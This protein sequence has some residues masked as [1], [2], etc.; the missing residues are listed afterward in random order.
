[1]ARS[2]F[3]TGKEDITVLAAIGLRN[4]PTI[5][6]ANDFLSLLTHMDNVGL[7][8]SGRDLMKIFSSFADLFDHS[9]LYE[10]IHGHLSCFDVFLLLQ[11]LRLIAF[12]LHWED[13]QNLIIDYIIEA[14]LFHRL[15]GAINA[16]LGDLPDTLPPSEMKIVHKLVA[17][18]DPHRK[19]DRSMPFNEMRMKFAHRTKTL[20]SLLQKMYNECNASFGS[21]FF[22]LGGTQIEYFP[23]AVRVGNLDDFTKNKFFDL[24]DPKLIFMPLIAPNSSVSNLL[25]NKANGLEI[26]KI[27]RT[28]QEA[29]VKKKYGKVSVDLIISEFSVQK[30]IMSKYL[31]FDIID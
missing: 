16:V 25:P 6:D 4:N 1:M 23:L 5:E 29:Y 28:A 19:Y 22:D 11:I 12:R 13:L 10:F 7:K 15:G 8:L 18:A 3:E 24:T 9:A 26:L 2:P 30:E 31:H 14:P 20:N 27:L 21:H 17:W